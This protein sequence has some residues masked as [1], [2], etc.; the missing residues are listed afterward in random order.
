[1]IME[2]QDLQV[3]GFVVQG[4]YKNLQ[5]RSAILDCVA[6]DSLGRHYDLEIQQ[7]DEGTV[8]KRA[9]YHSSLMDMNVLDAGKD[10]DRL[11]ERYVI[12]ISELCKQVTLNPFASENN[13]E[14]AYRIGI[15]AC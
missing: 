15:F 3:T 2:K 9:R 11:P 6:R 14:K 7:K 8:P 1:M 5:G 10:F 4:D 12:F 13:F